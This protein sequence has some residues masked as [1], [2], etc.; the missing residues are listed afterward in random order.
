MNRR[1]ATAAIAAG[2]VLVVLALFR[3]ESDEDRIKAR[4]DALAHTVAYDQG[5]NLLTRGVRI[6]RAFDDLFLPDVVVRAAELPG[7]N[8]GRDGLVALATRPP[9]A[10][11][12]ADLAFE[13][14]SVQ[15]DRA[16][17][18]ARVQADA[19]VTSTDPAGAH[20]DQR[21]AVFRFVDQGGTWRIAAV[22]VAADQHRPPEARP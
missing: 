18:S 21:Q 1:V 8:Q 13:H 3:S 17:H 7:E 19:V 22:D 20:R 11:E 15:V 9:G 16:H 12:T 2:V 10:L 4:L 14:V 6:Q 5:D